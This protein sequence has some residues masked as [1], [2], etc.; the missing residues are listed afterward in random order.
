MID[1]EQLH[2]IEVVD[3]LHRL[4]E[5]KRQQAVL[6]AD[7]AAVDLHE[8]VGVWRVVLAGRHP[9]ADDGR[10]DRVGD[11]LEPGAVP[12]EENRARAAAAID[13]L[14]LVQ[15][16]RR[17]LH[18]VLDDA[19]WPEQTDDIDLGRLSDAGQDLARVRPEEARRRGR[20]ELLPDRAGLHF[21]FRADAA[22]VVVQSGQRQP[23]RVAGV[24]AV[25]S[26]TDRRRDG[27]GDDEVGVVVAVE[28]AGEHLA[29]LFQ[30]H[31]RHAD[32]R[33]V[34]R[35]STL[36][37]APGLQDAALRACARGDQIQPAVVVVVDCRQ[38]EA[39]RERRTPGDRRA[40]T[41]GP[42]RSATPS[43]PGRRPT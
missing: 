17:E 30:R 10:A 28:V 12:R 41:T 2:L 26:Q 6:D 19:G 21:D 14:D 31:R 20:L 32:A 25:V 1:D 5:V 29:R 40:R 33:G 42:S 3:F 13:L 11:E 38:A 8:L 34:V 39:F 15:R 22:A 23:N 9:V 4:R 35:E 7:L 37:V 36:D 16:V 18:F 24:A 43:A 27:I